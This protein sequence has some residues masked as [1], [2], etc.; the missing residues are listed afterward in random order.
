MKRTWKGLKS[1]GLAD[2]HPETSP[3]AVE[4]AHPLW[5]PFQWKIS[6]LH[7]AWIGIKKRRHNYSKDLAKILV[8]IQTNLCHIYITI[9]IYVLFLRKDVSSIKPQKNLLGFKRGV[10]CWWW[11]C[12]NMGVL[13]TLISDKIEIAHDFRVCVCPWF[14]VKRWKCVEMHWNASCLLNDTFDARNPAPLGCVKNRRK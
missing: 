5:M 2:F 14:W 1:A 10:F 6:A 8:Y 7:C 3:E 4:L 9:Q 11:N 12:L 13:L